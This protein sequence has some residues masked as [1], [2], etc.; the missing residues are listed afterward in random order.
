MRC[1]RRSQL[2]QNGAA[3][4]F[5]MGV[6]AFATVAASAILVSQGIWSRQSQLSNEYV[7]AQ[8]MVQ[9]GAD[10][11]RAVLKD[12]R[13]MSN[14]DHLGEPWAQQ[15]PAMP[16]ENGR[17]T[18]QIHDQQ[19][20]FNLNNLVQD[21]KIIASQFASF[22]RL[23]ALLDLPSALADSLVDWLDADNAPHPPSGAEDEYYLSLN[24]PYLTANR[25]L[26]DLAE[27]LRVRG[28]TGAVLARMRPYV[29][30]L[31]GSTAIN[32]NTAP[33]EVLATVI[34]GLG[35]G[36]ARVLVAQRERAYFRDHA[37]FLNRLPQGVAVDAEDISTSSN[38][39]EASLHVT[40]GEAQAEGT[41]LLSR[42]DVGWPLII[43]CK[44]P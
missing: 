38:Y 20:M 17:L 30:A 9:A 40:I 8:A 28:F 6:V 15:I 37:D 25:P 1:G 22:K 36:N 42:V 16:I 21:G 3:I 5:A 11:M 31:P 10:W 7:Q 13:H 4:I 41:V 24:P 19:G 43:W 32:V 26:I 33:P 12:D 39:F 2:R 23:L 14:V 35:I 44:Y 18:A 29:T 34:E 27:L